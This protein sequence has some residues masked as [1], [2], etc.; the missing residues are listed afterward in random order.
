M[1]ISRL[2]VLTAAL[3]MIFSPSAVVFAG[4]AD[5]VGVKAIQGKDETWSFSVTVMHD[6]QGWDH[7]ADRWEVLGSDGEVLGV[8]VLLHPH[9]GEQPFT[10]GMDGVEIPEKVQKVLVRA[11]DSVHGYGGKEVVVELS[12]K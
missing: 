2:A 9:V 10:R 6:D 8:R 12:G 7:Y 1:K 5:V 3:L 4:E 11:R